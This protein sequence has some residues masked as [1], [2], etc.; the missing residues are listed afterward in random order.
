[1]A[2]TVRR[3]DYFYVQVPHRA[4]SGRPETARQEDG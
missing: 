3:V 2:D 1:M 4:G